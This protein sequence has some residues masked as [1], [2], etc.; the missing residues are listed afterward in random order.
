MGNQIQLECN[1]V[2]ATVTLNQPKRFNA[3]NEEMWR[4]LGD[5]M[6]KCDADTDLRCVIIRG[7]GGKAFSAGADIKE[8]ETTRKDK[9]TSL[10]YGK[11]TTYGFDSII[12]CRH[13][14]V[15]QIDG[16]CVGGGMGIASCCDIRVCGLSSKFGVP[17]KKLGLVEAHEEVRPLVEK[18]GANVALEIL[19]L[20]D[21][22]P[23][24]DALRMGLINQVVPDEEVAKTARATAEKIAEGAPLSARWHKKFIYRLLD[25][26]P[27]TDAEIDEAFDCYDT[28]DFQTG[29]RAFVEKTYP[30]FAGR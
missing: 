19:L 3:M 2:I 29:R 5:T 28:E 12:A 26:A 17:V 11:V 15:A 24:A 30:V 4:D 1:G 14:V 27:L 20:G 23:V 22:F 25:P 18:F 13:P 16:L 21:V 9:N 10:I 7:A 6:K 8:F